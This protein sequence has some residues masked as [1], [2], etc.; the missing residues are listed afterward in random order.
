MIIY[1]KTKDEFMDDLLN[2]SLSDMIEKEVW[3]KAHRHSYGE[4]MS[5]R[6]SLPRMGLILSESNLPSDIG[7]A[8]EYRIPYTSM[9]VDMI[10]T[11]L[12]SEGRNSAVVVELKQWDSVK[13]TDY[14][15]IIL[16]RYRS[17][18][19]EVDH[20]SHQAWSYVRMIEDY[21]AGVQDNNI[22]IQPCTYLHNYIFNDPDPL[23]NEKYRD[24]IEK[25]PIFTS[26]DGSKLIDFIKDRIKE[27][28]SLK[29]IS[30]IENGKLR[31][32][33]SLQDCIAS[34]MDGNE[35]FIM[36]D[37][38]K[39]I[40]EKIVYHQDALINHKGSKKSKR[41]IIVKGGPGTGKSVI[42]VNLLARFTKNGYS[43]A[44]VSKTK[45]PRS[46]YESKLTGSIRRCEIDCLFK[47]SGS[48]TNPESNVYDVLII[49]EA[50]RL[51]EKSG[52]YN[53]GE[54][55]VKEIINS[56]RLSVFFIDEGQKV[57]YGDIGTI[58]A[59]RRYAAEY[60][61][62]VI[63]LELSS[64]FRCS[65]SDG[66]IEWLDSLLQIQGAPSL[67]E[68]E[69]FDYDFRVFDDPCQMRDEI[70]ELNKVA[71]KCRLLA[72]TCWDWI[73][74]GKT[75][76]NVHD[77]TIPG[78]DFA[79]SWNLEHE[80]TWAIDPESVNEVGSVH[81]AQ[82]LEF[83]YVGV[84]LGPDIFY[85]LETCSVMTDYNARY[86]HDPTIRGLKSHQPVEERAVIGDQIIRNTYKV[87]M[88]RGM[89]GC[90]VYCTDPN[91]RDYIKRRLD[92][93][94]G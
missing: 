39:V 62:K 46:V 51:N 85:D 27:G 69:Y 61:S 22:C 35:E 76:T 16:T 93:V 55:Q 48:F 83:E 20:P 67:D 36:I 92:M 40:F 91:L 3:A 82:G 9:C 33:K 77:I 86:K 19:K 71:N 37:Q 90:Y 26:R 58:E 66:Y 11:G 59:I 34:M 44:F 52:P 38:Q 49:D 23:L 45:A 94:K 24:H 29:T 65:G 89:K 78:T 88:S 47:W 13:S 21:N 68:S 8:I 6:N 31:P 5:W 57:T 70:F 30:M 60:N 74:G 18:K 75:N 12:D 42:A 15:D 2:N 50:H 73:S 79:M 32:S 14:N 43:A 7:V 54:N 28:D 84:L 64:Q 53:R 63:E 87:L 17:G 81:T 80:Y 4:V 72:G 10:I 41:T 1:S 56:S 25:A